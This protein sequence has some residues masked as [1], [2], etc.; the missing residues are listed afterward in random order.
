MRPGICIDFPRNNVASVA[1]YVSKIPAVSTNAHPYHHRRVVPF[2]LFLLFFR[3][4]RF[5][6]IELTD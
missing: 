2:V 1:A 3:V 6:L 4:W 5:A